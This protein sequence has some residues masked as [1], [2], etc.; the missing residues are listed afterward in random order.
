MD[1]RPRGALGPLTVREIVPSTPPHP[2]PPPPPRSFHVSTSTLLA[3]LSSPCAELD[4]STEVVLALLRARGRL[5]CP[6]AARL[7]LGAGRLPRQRGPHVPSAAGAAGAPVAPYAPLARDALPTAL[8]QGCTDARHCLRVFDHVRPGLG[9][10]TESGGV[11]GA[12]KTGD[13]ERPEGGRFWGGEVE[14]PRGVGLVYSCMRTTSR[15]LLSAGA[16]ELCRSRSRPRSNCVIR[17]PSAGTTSWCHSRFCR[18]ARTS[19]RG[20]LWQQELST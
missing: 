14:S 18:R 17:F 3:R 4:R 1:D 11:G 8:S 2:T 9:K 7:S 19:T 6:R 10:G 12:R 15:L 20:G 5:E 16:F 13:C